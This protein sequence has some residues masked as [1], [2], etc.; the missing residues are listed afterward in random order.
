MK[1]ILVVCE[2]NICRSPMAAGLLATWLPNV[3]VRSAGLS[4][5]V[6][7]PADEHAVE[8]MK[9]RAI[10]I[11]SHRAAAIHR[12]MCRVSELILVMDLEQKNRLEDLYPETRGRVFRVAEHGAV[13]VPDPYRQSKDAFRDALRLIERG[14]SEWLRLIE[15]LK[16][17]QA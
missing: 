16:K 7:R 8:L 4:A 17:T 11:T 15:K 2:G 6:G 3:T 5:L 12:E 13:D 9:E 1:S 14:A 10:D